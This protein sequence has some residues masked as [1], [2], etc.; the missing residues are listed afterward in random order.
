M[1]RTNCHVFSYCLVAWCLLVAGCGRP[2]LTPLDRRGYY[3]LEIL[4]ETDDDAMVQIV[5]WASFLP[6]ENGKYIEY[7][8]VTVD[9]DTVRDDLK[10]SSGVFDLSAGEK[11]TFSMLSGW[12]SGTP[13]DSRQMRGF[14]EIG[15]YDKESGVPY[16]RYMYD[17]VL[18]CGGDADCRHTHDIYGDEPDRSVVYRR[19][20]GVEER[21]F[22]QDPDRPFYLERDPVDRGL[23][24]IVITFVPA[25]EADAG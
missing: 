4:N 7:G 13:N 8:G 1:K 11:K 12:G 25:A 17:L 19:S 3:R 16:K 10:N 14:S 24:R 5:M 9:R 21:L 15:F 18:Y 20:D 23:G 6:P 2:D 22:A